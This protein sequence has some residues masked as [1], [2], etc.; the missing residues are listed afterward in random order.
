MWSNKSEEKTPHTS[1]VDAKI[2]LP[3][4]NIVTAV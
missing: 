4:V 3:S 1:T 2:T